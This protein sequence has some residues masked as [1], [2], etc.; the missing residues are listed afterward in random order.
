MTTSPRF[1]RWFAGI[2]IGDIPL[3]GGKNASLGEMFHELSSQGVKVPDG[4]AVNLFADEKMFPALANPVQMQVD[5]KGRLWA[6][7]WSTYPK[8][9]PLKESKD[10]LLIFHDDNN[11][12][13]ADRVTEFA[14]MG[15]SFFSP[16]M[17]GTTVT[18][19]ARV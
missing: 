1:I 11:D 2:S 19:A 6:A 16:A 7:C 10:A 3:V 8:W 12:G 15:T 18:P 9:E 14:S 17:K 4:F 5:T 13:K